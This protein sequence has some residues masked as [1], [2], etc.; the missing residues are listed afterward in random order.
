MYICMST[1]VYIYIYIYVYAYTYLAEDVIGVAKTGSGKT[2]GPG[3]DSL[4]DR[5]PARDP[6]EG[7]SSSN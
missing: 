3:G 4:S 5:F 2:L 7:T 6:P 1:Y